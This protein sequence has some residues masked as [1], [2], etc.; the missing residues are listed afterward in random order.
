MSSDLLASPIV[1]FNLLCGGQCQR[2]SYARRSDHVSY[3]GSLAVLW[4]DW[5]KQMGMHGFGQKLT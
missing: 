3:A 5:P 4:K 2:E 1:I